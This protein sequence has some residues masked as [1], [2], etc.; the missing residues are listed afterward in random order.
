MSIINDTYFKYKI[1]SSTLDFKKC[2][3]N[4]YIN[5]ALQKPIKQFDKK[6]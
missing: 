2:P 4:I 5:D 3:I 6:S 1:I